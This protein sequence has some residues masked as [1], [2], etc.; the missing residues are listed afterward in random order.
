MARGLE[1]TCVNCKHWH[2]SGGESGYSEMTPGSNWFS[3]CYKNH[4]YASGIDIYTEDY[5]KKLL[6]AQTCKDFEDYK[7]K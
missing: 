2:F 6:K 3:D 4:W 7:Q 1:L 5:R